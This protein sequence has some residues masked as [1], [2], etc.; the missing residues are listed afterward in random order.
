MKPSTLHRLLRRAGLSPDLAISIVHD[1][2]R[3]AESV[4][5]RAVSAT[6]T[7][8][9]RKKLLAPLNTTIKSLQSQQSR[10]STEDSAL[11]AK[12]LHVLLAIRER[13]KQATAQVK[14]RADER[15]LSGIHADLLERGL[16]SEG[17][18]MNWTSWVEQKIKD[19]VSV[20]FDLHY[21]SDYIGR[22]MAPF[23]NGAH[24]SANAR[25]WQALRAALIVERLNSAD[26]PDL[27]ACT[28]YAL[29]QVAEHEQG[30]G[31]SAPVRW[32]HLLDGTHKEMYAQWKRTTMGGLREPTTIP[33]PAAAL[34]REGLKEEVRQ[35]MGRTHTKQLSAAL[36]R[37]KMRV[38]AAS[39]RIKQGL[40]VHTTPDILDKK[41]AAELAL[42]NAQYAEDLA[43]MENAHSSH[44]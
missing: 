38:Y 20:K 37:H 42:M 41:Y 26:Y 35:K 1:A 21:P 17:P 30:G 31:P 3:E 24:N 2:Q 14:S 43:C 39:Q 13:I 9:N 32:Q 36:K 12:Y 8:A 22:R 29:E 23:Y 27:V 44:N 11:Y 6:V 4:R 40:N 7:A 15:T 19:K 34:M 10:W 25:R 5:N 18:V 16:A 33:A 28:T